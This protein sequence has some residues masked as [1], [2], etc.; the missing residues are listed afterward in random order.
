MKKFVISSNDLKPAL[1]KLGLAINEKSVLPVTKNILC[2]VGADNIVEMIA[3]IGRQ[4]F[5][6]AD[7][8]LNKAVVL[9]TRINQFFGLNWKAN[10]KKFKAALPGSNITISCI[11]TA[12]GR[13]DIS[14]ALQKVNAKEKVE[15]YDKKYYWLDI[16]NLTKTG[17][18]VLGTLQS[19]EQPKKN[20]E[21]IPQLPTVTRLFPQLSKIK[22]TDQG[23]SCSLAEALN[24]Q[25]LYI[26][27]IMAQ[28]G[29]N[30][31]WKLFRD[32]MIKHHGCYV[33]LETLSVNPI[34][35]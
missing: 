35:I 19:I 26:N 11:D 13:I 5:S 1:K 27:S 12:A 25:D 9:T 16:G 28:F 20:K 15:P 7:L 18:V 8:G 22:E 3:N 23:P 29:C 21:Y 2:K 17:Q 33:N 10:N 32:G 14:G 30:M 31:I 34:K 4:L 6:P 24:K